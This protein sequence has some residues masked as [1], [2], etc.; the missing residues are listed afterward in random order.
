MDNE[1]LMDRDIIGDVLDLCHLT[2]VF[3]QNKP[4]KAA[5]FDYETEILYL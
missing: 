3:L 5:T 2:S 1:V 4:A